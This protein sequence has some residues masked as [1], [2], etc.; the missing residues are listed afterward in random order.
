MTGEKI[1]E[2]RK[3]ERR[4]KM[5]NFLCSGT[6]QKL[7]ETPK[8]RDNKQVTDSVVKGLIN[9]IIPNLDVSE[10]VS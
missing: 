9:Q 10:T 1:E 7:T 2:R 3:R 4:K 8:A 5:I 6:V